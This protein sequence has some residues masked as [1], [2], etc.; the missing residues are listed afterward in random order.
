MGVRF[1][2]VFHQAAVQLVVVDDGGV[3]QLIVDL[4]I[5]VAHSP[6]AV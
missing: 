6:D 2:I 4:V 3:L 5:T 1:F